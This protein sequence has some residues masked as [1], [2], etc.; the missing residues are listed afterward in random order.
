MVGNVCLVGRDRRARQ[1][2][3]TARRSVPTTRNIALLSNKPFRENWSGQALGYDKRI[4]PESLKQFLQDIRLLGVTG[5]P[6]HLGLELVASNR[7]LP[8]I[9][10]HLRVAQIVFHF[11]FKLHLRHHRLQRWLGA[12]VGVWPDPVAPVN[13]FNRPLIRYAL[14]KRQCSW[15]ELRCRLG[16]KKS[17]QCS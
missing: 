7:P 14:C 9:L 6:L 16:T 3:R 2:E 13:V 17:E 10:Q 4:V 5:H 8:V 1:S 11:L 15:G 12:G